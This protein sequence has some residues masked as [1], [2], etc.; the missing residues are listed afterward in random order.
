MYVYVC[1]RLGV[2]AIVHLLYQSNLAKGERGRGLPWFQT[3]ES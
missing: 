2:C 3:F 1:V